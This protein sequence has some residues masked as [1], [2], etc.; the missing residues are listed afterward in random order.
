LLFVIRGNRFDSAELV[1]GQS[2]THIQISSFSIAAESRSHN[3]S[4]KLS[5]FPTAIIACAG[6]FSGGDKPHPYLFGEIS[7]V[8]AGFIPAC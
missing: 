5:D 3:Q 1:E 4:P 2:R 8:V 6:Q 7:F